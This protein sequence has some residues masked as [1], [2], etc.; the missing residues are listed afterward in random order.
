MQGRVVCL[1]PSCTGNLPPCL[2]NYRRGKGRP[3]KV[4]I[5][6]SPDLTALVFRAAHSTQPLTVVY[7]SQALLG[8]WEPWAQAQATWHPTLSTSPLLWGD[9]AASFLLSDHAGPACR[10]LQDEHKG[11]AVKKIT[12]GLGL[13]FISLQQLKLLV[14]HH[15]KSL[16]R[17]CGE[18]GSACINGLK[19]KKLRAESR[20]HGAKAPE[21]K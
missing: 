21:V 3:V 20:R 7:L 9:V 14:S 5:R 1:R 18:I 4:T 12:P 6:G 17:Q 15:W 10:S 2:P 11:P 16:E 13:V 8:V 19:K